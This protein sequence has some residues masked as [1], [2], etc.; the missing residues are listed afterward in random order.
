M[1]RST[2]CNENSPVQYDELGRNWELAPLMTSMDVNAYGQPKFGSA[3]KK[4]TELQQEIATAVAL[5]IPCACC[6]HLY[7]KIERLERQHA[8]TLRVL[9]AIINTK[10]TAKDD[11]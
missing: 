1:V 7:D 5:P 6:R 10:L 8:R 4:R 11:A 3:K 2:I 9:E